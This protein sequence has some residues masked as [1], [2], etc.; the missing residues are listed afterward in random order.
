M[1]G[2]VGSPVGQLRWHQLSL[3]VKGLVIL[4]ILLMPL[5]LAMVLLVVQTQMDA[6]TDRQIT[7]TRRTRDAAELVLDYA[8]DAETSVRGYVATGNREFLDLYLSILADLE[9]VAATVERAE[10]PRDARE[11]LAAQYELLERLRTMAG[12]LGDAEQETV[13]L[14]GKQ[15]MD[16]VRSVL[17]SYIN[18]KEEDLS[19]A[20]GRRDELHTR[21]RWTLWMGGISGVLGGSLAITLFVRDIAGRVTKLQ[22]NSRRIEDSRPLDDIPG[23]D[24]ISQL[25]SV[26]EETR[27]ALVHKDTLRRE[28]EQEIIRSRD[29]A[30]RANRAKSEFLSRMSH[31][32]RTPL[33]A[34][35]GFA[36][37]LQMDRLS[38]DQRDSVGHIAKGGRHLLDLIN[39][40]LD[41]SRIEAGELSL[42]LE[43]VGLLPLIEES[44]A[45]MEPL[46]V[47][48]DI[49][50][51]CNF[52]EDL[53]GSH[54]MTDRQRL[55]QIVLNLLSNG[56]KYNRPGGSVT[57]T[58][59]DLR[60]RLALEVAD[61]GLG[62]SDRDLEDLFTPFDRLGA[63]RLDVEGTGLGLPLSRRLAEAIGGD[64]EVES[65]VGEGSTFLLTLPKAEAT[66]A[67]GPPPAV[68]PL[69]SR[70]FAT[71]TLLYIEDNLSNLKL[72]ERI[73]AHRPGVELLTALQGRLGIDLAREHLPD[74]I[75][76]DLHLPDVSGLEVLRTLKSDLRTASIPVVMLSADATTGQIERFRSAGALDYLT[77]PLDVQRFLALLD[78]TLVGDVA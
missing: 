57:V 47:R 51:R 21:T 15:N 48:G 1:E 30:D 54:V 67:D 34:I 24:E 36:Q 25:G 55:K 72:V 46:A 27:Q 53:A 12:S 63:E 69:P 19:A 59:R 18:G 64:I 44:M 70:D 43:P 66:I 5:L 40:V 3:R 74:V 29:E 73:M 77:K 42:S 26:L 14:E 68:G 16:R 31:E 56:I 4:A 20:L 13:L 28:A 71:A 75:V 35:L 78:R 10:I 11:L 41:I 52:P 22:Q 17:R 39:E 9:T 50:L 38:E 23:A 61:T 33:N 6:T 32:L 58:G 7:E 45:L 49:R 60:D 65:Q 8:I 76:L 37:L 2:I 62:L